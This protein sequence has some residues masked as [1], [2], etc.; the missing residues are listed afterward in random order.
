VN[1]AEPQRATDFFNT[2]LTVDIDA[3]AKEI[4]NENYETLNASFQELGV[5]PPTFDW[6]PDKDALQPTKIGRLLEY[7]EA[8]RENRE[9]PESREIDPVD[10][11]YALG[12]ILLT[13]FVSEGSD[14]RY[15]VYGTNVIQFSGF[16]LT[17][18]TISESIIPPGSRAFYLATYKAVRLRRAPVFTINYPS[19]RETLRQWNRITLPFADA[20]GEINRFIVGIFPIE[21]IP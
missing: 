6:R 20:D 12:N 5:I 1:H 9:V 10:F 11:P 8:L 16:D 7:W 2:L 4:S 21:H 3:I 13:E 19:L 15:R 17:G 14:L 18:K